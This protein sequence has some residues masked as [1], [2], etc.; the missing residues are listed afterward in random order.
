[1]CL[2]VC[3]PWT[4]LSAST[5]V[6][7]IIMLPSA[8]L[9]LF[10]IFAQVSIDRWS[11]NQRKMYLWVI[12]WQVIQS[13][14]SPKPIIFV[15]NH[16]FFNM[17]HERSMKTPFTEL[18]NTKCYPCPFSDDESVRMEQRDWGN[19]A[20]IILHAY[21][22]K[23]RWRNA[24]ILFFAS[25]VHLDV[26]HENKKSKD[27]QCFVLISSAF[28]SF[29]FFILLFQIIHSGKPVIQRLFLI[30]IPIIIFIWE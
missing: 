23:L 6:K 1:M 19:V 18:G 10:A 29:H 30:I 16:A 15:S 13:L 2:C 5:C 21:F 9:T 12:I 22:V 25:N 8:F 26:R 24:W 4:C 3:S 28:V 17:R 7:I 20:S 27:F 14:S 11:G